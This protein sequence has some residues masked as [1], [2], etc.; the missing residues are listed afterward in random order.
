MEGGLAFFRTVYYSRLHK[1]R[2]GMPE[3]PLPLH[4]TSPHALTSYCIQRRRARFNRGDNWHFSCFAHDL[5]Y[6]GCKH[7]QK[8]P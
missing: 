7:Q 3:M 1:L 5:L 8:V 4:P 2:H 6:D